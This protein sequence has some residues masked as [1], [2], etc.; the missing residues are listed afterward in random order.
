MGGATS[1]KKRITAAKDFPPGGKGRGREKGE[2][3]LLFGKDP[4][5]I[6]GIERGDD[7]GRE[8][9]ARWEWWKG[10]ERKVMEFFVRKERASRLDE[11]KPQ[12]NWKKWRMLVASVHACKR[13]AELLRRGKREVKPIIRICLGGRNDVPNSAE[14]KT[15][16]HARTILK[17]EKKRREEG[18]NSTVETRR[19]KKSSCTTIT[20]AQK[21]E[22]THRSERG[23]ER[24]TGSNVLF[25]CA[26]GGEETRSFTCPRKEKGGTGQGSEKLLLNPAESGTVN[27]AYINH[28][29]GGGKRE[30]NFLS[31]GRVYARGPIN[32]RWKICTYTPRGT[33]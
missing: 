6:R 28:T 15:G 29:K 18:T 17:S 10:K 24:M 13:A 12:K 23:K 30:G 8:E 4:V 27:T 11:K 7:R 20:L 2:L 26:G 19:G 9:W 25:G 21:K 32:E 33:M 5:T 1:E 22:G 31:E 14:K 3:A 16:R